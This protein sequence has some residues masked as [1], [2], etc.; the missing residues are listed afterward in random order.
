MDAVI[1]FDLNRER[2]RLLTLDDSSAMYEELPTP[3]E[4][5]NRGDYAG[6]LRY[7]FRGRELRGLPV[8]VALPDTAVACDY[9]T[10]PVLKNQMKQAVKV[11]FESCYQ[12]HEKLAYHSM[13]YA[14]SRKH[15]TYF[16]VMVRRSLLE[17]VAEGV[18]VVGGSL[19]GITS[20]PSGV[21]NA[22]LALGGKDGNGAGKHGF[23]SFLARRRWAAEGD[24]R[25]QRPGNALFVDVQADV[26]RFVL[27]NRE[28]ALC[29]LFQPYGY[30]ILS[31][32]RLQQEH[33]L[34]SHAAAELAVL[35]AME[36]ARRKKAIAF[37]QATERAGEAS[38]PDRELPTSPEN[39][40]APLNRP[41]RAADS[42]GL[43][44]GARTEAEEMETGASRTFGRGARKA[45]KKYPR[46]LQ[47]E[48]PADAEGFVM[49]NFRIIQKYALLFAQTVE[50]DPLFGRPDRIVLNLP[51][52]FSFVPERLNRE[53]DNGIA[54]VLLENS[55]SRE[56]CLMENLD[57][58]GAS[59]MD[60]CNRI[61]R[62]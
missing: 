28:M 51:E 10:L 44:D 25:G 31:H 7:A 18:R 26:T 17:H 56:Q 39:G 41:H 4:L 23:R 6:M 33:M 29:S 11:E 58:Y 45:E 16:Y 2:V 40:D 13:R 24:H 30:R 21:A 27:A 3:R 49:E 12:H 46:F 43:R 48:Q 20:S 19:K 14:A 61:Y 52:E 62:F 32:S 34:T 54:F 35:N 36:T 57:L 55:G 60:R 37:P 59:L 50:H 1:G 22:F 42:E 8:R 38:A 15:A 53:S 9:F 5:S 47:R